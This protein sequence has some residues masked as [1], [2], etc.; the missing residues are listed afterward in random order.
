MQANAR[1]VATY[2]LTVNLNGLGYGLEGA[3]FDTGSI[4]F[5]ER[6]SRLRV[7]VA[8][9]VA[10]LGL[11]VPGSAEPRLSSKAEERFASIAI[12]AGWS[13]SEL[14]GEPIDSRASETPKSTDCL[15]PSRIHPKSPRLLDILWLLNEVGVTILG[16]SSSKAKKTSLY[17][18]EQRWRLD[19]I[20]YEPLVSTSNSHRNSAKPRYGL[21]C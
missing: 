2:F 17:R 8:P 11:V 14:S 3:G 16:S 20:T 5:K 9:P 15:T 13:F 18:L 6:P 4:S 7:A 19:V 1:Q 10:R 12:N 21:R